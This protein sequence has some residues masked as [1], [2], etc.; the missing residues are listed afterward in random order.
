MTYAGVY[1]SIPLVRH[2]VDHVN[3]LPHALVSI[4]IVDCIFVLNAAAHLCTVSF[5]EIQKT[6][7]ILIRNVTE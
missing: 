2:G 3:C 6:I 7:T 5:E 4:A 1:N